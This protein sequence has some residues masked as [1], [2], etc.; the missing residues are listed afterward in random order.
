MGL[1]QMIFGDSELEK[2]Q[3][4]KL[5]RELGI[6]SDCHGS[7]YVPEARSLSLYYNPEFLHCPACNGTG[8]A[9]KESL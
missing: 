9:K 2:L 8:K 5:R 7:G 4:E 1:W 6:C 3:A